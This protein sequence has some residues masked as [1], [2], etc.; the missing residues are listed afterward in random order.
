[1]GLP[2]S[3][4]ARPKRRESRSLVPPHRKGSGQTRGGPIALGRPLPC[5]FP[6]SCSTL[7]EFLARVSR[8]N[9]PS[10]NFSGGHLK[11]HVRNVGVEGSN[12]FC[13]T[14]RSPSSR[15]FQRIA[16]N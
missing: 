6:I 9:K 1:D 11:H 14:I 7:L 3:D 2:Q 10:G 5:G 4:R 8:L 16:R 15:T 12:P 13:S